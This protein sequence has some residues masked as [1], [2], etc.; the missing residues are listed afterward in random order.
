MIF[1]YYLNTYVPINIDPFIIKRL[2]SATR[3]ILLVS[4]TMVI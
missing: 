1:S 3:K 4:K 2:L